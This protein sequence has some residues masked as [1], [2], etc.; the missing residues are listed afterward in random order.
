MVLHIELRILTVFKVVIALSLLNFLPE[1]SVGF[2]ELS[3]SVDRMDQ[4]LSLRVLLLL[5]VEGRPCRCHPRHVHA[6]PVQG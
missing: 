2:E 1:L 5:V 6:L 4:A 3:H